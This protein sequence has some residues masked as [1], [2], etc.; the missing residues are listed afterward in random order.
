MDAQ[1]FPGGSV[2]K[3]LPAS[4]GGQKVQ[5]SLLSQEDPWRRKRQPAAVFLPGAYHGKMNLV[6]YSPSG[7]KRVGHD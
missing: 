7:H 3:N 5:V 2:I 1:G 6:G 4:A